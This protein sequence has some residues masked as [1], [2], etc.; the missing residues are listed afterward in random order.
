MNEMIQYSAKRL[1]LG[2][3]VI[4]AVTALL[5]I[6]MQMMPGDPIQLISNPRVSPEK[7]AELEL[8]WGLDKPGYI[9]Y[10]YWLKNIIRGDFG[11]SITTGQKVSE[12]IKS[13]LPFTLLL[14]GCSLIIEYLIAIPLGLFAASRKDGIMDRSLIVITIVLWSM[15]AF[16]LGIILI[17]I[18][19]VWLRA[20]PLS[21]YSGIKSLILPSLTM[22]LPVIAQI[23]R[24]TRSEVIEVLREKYVVTAYAKGLKEK[25]VLVKHVLRN[26]LIPITV[27]FFLSLPWLIGGS[28][29]VESV[30]AWPGMGRLLWKSISSQ[31]FPV[32]QGI[33]FIIA[34]LTVI[35]NI[36]G[37][38]ISGLLD[39]R[40]RLE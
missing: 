28:V 19:G 33:I 21:G 12:L 38:I 27:M 8:R 13:R 16:W 10:I 29:I 1:M 14:T 15:P 24:L 20:L 35:S 34:L 39:P 36:I 26:A 9:Q 4:L 30:F 6:I 11:T 25:K 3:L 17:I 32:V 18:F 23:F 5:F 31:D 37:D 40:I 7:I 22:I 2:L